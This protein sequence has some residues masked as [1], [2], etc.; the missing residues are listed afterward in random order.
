V[1]A[2]TTAAPNGVTIS[3]ARGTATLP[4]I[5]FGGSGA[6]NN[7]GLFSRAADE[8]N[9]AAGGVEVLR[10]TTT[11]LVG[12]AIAPGQLL[13][14]TR[15][16]AALPAFASLNDSNTGMF[17]PFVS[18]NDAVGISTGGTERVRVKTEGVD[19]LSGDLLRGG[20][21][22]V[23]AQGAA[24]ADAAG[25]TEITTINAILARLRAHGLIAT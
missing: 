8:V 11:T 18:G 13:A 17:F 7:T 20:T 3:L 10:A 14:A 25:G 4:A 2:A 6:D 19:I 1:A 24:I 15:G 21:K 12:G 22:V 5:N 16:T 23:G 9:L